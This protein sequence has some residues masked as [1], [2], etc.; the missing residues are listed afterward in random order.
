LLE[1]PTGIFDLGE[2]HGVQDSCSV[3]NGKFVLHM[4]AEVLVNTHSGHP[5]PALHKTVGDI[6]VFTKT[7]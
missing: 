3:V 6:Q 5:L 4:V 2:K 7:N 1:T